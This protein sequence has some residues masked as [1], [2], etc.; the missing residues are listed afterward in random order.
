MFGLFNQSLH[1][2][3]DTILVIDLKNLHVNDL[4]FLEVVADL[5]DAFM[6]DLADVQQT[7]AARQNLNDSAEVEQSLNLAFV[8]LTDFNGS[9]KLFNTTAGF[10]TSG[11]VNGS[12]GNGTV[13]FD[14]DLS[15]GFFRQ[16]TNHSAALADLSS[17]LQRLRASCRECAYGLP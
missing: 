10:C 13:V 6:R 7:V 2:K 4:A 9:G 11:F 3:T 5:V 15:A 17:D 12:D 14:V 16:S 8:N 1:G